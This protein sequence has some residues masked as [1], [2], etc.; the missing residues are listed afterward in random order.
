MK[1]TGLS[2]YYLI[3]RVDLVKTFDIDVLRLHSLQLEQKVV[4]AWPPMLTRRPTP[5]I[6]RAW[7]YKRLRLQVLLR[8]N[9]IL[10]LRDPDQS[11]ERERTRSTVGVV[12]ETHHTAPQYILFSHIESSKHA[13]H[14]QD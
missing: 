8:G 14:D 9:L 11:R 12:R 3:A 2:S 4:A 7:R 10:L 13:N 5:L 1:E 6:T